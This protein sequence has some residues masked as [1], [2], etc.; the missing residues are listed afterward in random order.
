MSNVQYERTSL[1][2]TV[3]YYQRQ[4]DLAREYGLD[5][6]AQIYAGTIGR[7]RQQAEVLRRDLIGGK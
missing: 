5:D 2:L 6:V 4:A 1:L 3:E 7:V